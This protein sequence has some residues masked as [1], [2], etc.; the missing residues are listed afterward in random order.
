MK[1]KFVRPVIEEI[2]VEPNQAIAACKGTTLK[3]Y[4]IDQGEDANY[5][6][7]KNFDTEDACKKY[8][9]NQPN[10]WTYNGTFVKDGQKRVIPM[11]W[12]SF[13]FNGTHYSGTWRDY[14]VNYEYDEDS[15]SAIFQ[16]VNSPM[17]PE[18]VNYLQT[19]VKS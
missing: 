15:G 1:K 10:I 7:F 12:Y 4:F 13:N 11:M 16:Q 2:N 17:T 5:T 18:A 9:S 6:S 8:W 14:N 19:Q 3:W